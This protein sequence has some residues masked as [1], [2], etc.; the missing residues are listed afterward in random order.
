MGVP[1]QDNFNLLHLLSE[2]SVLTDARGKVRYV[3]PVYCNLFK[4]PHTEWL[5]RSPY[6]GTY[7]SEPATATNFS[8]FV[9]LEKE[10]KQKTY[11]EWNASLMPDGGTLFLGR[12]KTARYHEDEAL[13]TAAASAEEA[14]LSKMRFLATMS[15]EMR[16]PL[17]G[18]LGMTGLLL[19]SDL[20]PNQRTHAEAVRESGTALLTLIND[21]LDYSKIEAGKLEL[22]ESA[23]DPQSLIQ[24]VCELLSPRAVH[25]DLE[26]T[27]YIDPSVPNRLLGDEARLRQILLNLA[28]NG[29]KFTEAGGVSVT[30][31]AEPCETPGRVMA[32]FSVKDTG[33]GIQQQSLEKIFDEFAQADSSHARKF[34]GTGL[35]LSIAQHLVEAMGGS[36]KVT[37]RVGQGS[38]FSF[39][40]PLTTMTSRHDRS[41]VRE[42][43]QTV[44]ALVDSPVLAEALQKQLQ[45]ARVRKIEITHDA[46]IAMRLLKR[47][48]GATLLCDLSYAAQFGARLAPQAGNAIVLLSPVARGRLEAFRRAGFHG[49][50]IKPIRQSSLVERITNR[51]M[52]NRITHR[53]DALTNKPAPGPR[54]LRVLLAEDNQINAVLATAIIKRAGHSIDVAGNG[55]EAVENMANAPYDIV[56]MD[57]HMPEMDGLE[58][59]RK[60]RAMGGEPAETPIIALTANAMKSDRETCLTAGMNDFITKPFDPNDLLERINKWANGTPDAEEAEAEALAQEIG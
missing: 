25:K 51:S 11:L 5:G 27:S 10:E 52:P 42:I 36:I 53:L 38:E 29:V 43:N 44:V 47:N 1:E 28:G 7:T 33:V 13:R 24:S 57:M 41:Q 58:A 54:K 59:T 60:I 37:S 50:L 35:G 45:A 16:T 4:A 19:D 3:N 20:D 12:D 39:R 23:L 15:H 21:I 55:K 40:V 17:N 6:F 34:E 31:T 32:V 22:E 56:L 9:S 48:S 18:I 8:T 49:Y 14:S 46:D 26:I 2:A 30:L